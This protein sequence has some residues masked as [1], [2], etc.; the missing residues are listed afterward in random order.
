MLTDTLHR[1]HSV[2]LIQ[3]I[4]EHHQPHTCSCMQRKSR[5][6]QCWQGTRR[7]PADTQMVE[8]KLHRCRSAGRILPRFDHQLSHTQSYTLT[9]VRCS[10]HLRRLLDRH[11][12]L[13]CMKLPEG[14]LHRYRPAALSDTTHEHPL[15]R[16][17]SYTQRRTR[18]S[19]RSG[20]TPPRQAD[21]RVLAD[22]LH[23]CRSVLLTQSKHER[24]Q[25]HMHL[26]MQR[27]TQHSQC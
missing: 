21:T 6:S 20:D 12:D 2:Q 18:H 15:L 7:H 10:L 1:C 8:D 26:C 9:T 17:H 11:R 23:R 4:C 19:Q 14:T 3:S 5:H 25:A 13:S 24:Q 27:K 22:T 16:R